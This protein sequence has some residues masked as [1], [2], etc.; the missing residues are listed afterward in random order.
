VFLALSFTLGITLPA[1]AQVQTFNQCMATSQ[2]RASLSLTKAELRSLCENNSDEVVACTLTMMQGN[3]FSG[4][5]SQALKDCRKQ[6]IF[7]YY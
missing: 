3:R 1:G 2:A 7:N 4:N 5:L 6:F